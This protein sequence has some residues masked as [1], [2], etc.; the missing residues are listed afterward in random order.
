M[1]SSSIN[2]TPED[3]VSPKNLY[4]KKDCP[5]YRQFSP[6]NMKLYLSASAKTPTGHQMVKTVSHPRPLSTIDAAQ[7]I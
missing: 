4:C 2:V 5:G 7:V 6:T 1:V 3:R